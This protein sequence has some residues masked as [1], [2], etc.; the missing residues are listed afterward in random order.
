MGRLSALEPRVVLKNKLLSVTEVALHLNVAS[1]TIY[2]WI[3]QKKIP[4]HRVGKQ[5]RFIQ[6]EIDVWVQSGKSAAEIISPEPEKG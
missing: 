5:W 3:V 1:I 2:R 4:C 6:S